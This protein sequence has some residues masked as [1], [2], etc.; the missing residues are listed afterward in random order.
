MP[1]IEG[2]IRMSEIK[3]FSFDGTL[4]LHKAKITK[5]THFLITHFLPFD[6]IVRIDELL[7]FPPFPCRA[8]PERSRGRGARGGVF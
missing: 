3:S 8:C 7:F 5:Q 4:V 6:S 1:I 2:A